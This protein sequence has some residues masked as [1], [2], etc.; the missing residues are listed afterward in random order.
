MVLPAFPQNAQKR[1]CGHSP[2]GFFQP[3]IVPSFFAGSS[4]TSAGDLRHIKRLADEGFNI[5]LTL[6][7]KCQRR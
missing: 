4:K 2:Y 7:Q 6:Y 3:R 1:S 5:R